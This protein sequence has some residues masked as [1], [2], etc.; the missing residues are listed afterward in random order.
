MRFRVGDAPA[1]VP[2]VIGAGVSRDGNT[3]TRRASPRPRPA[4]VTTV[5]A[6]AQPA[7]RV[8]AD[9]PDLGHGPGLIER[10]AAGA[11]MGAPARDATG[12]VMAVVRGDEG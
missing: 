1:G 8:I 6:A 12:A 10:P 11:E 2:V 5:A 3:G 7:G 4:P 9:L